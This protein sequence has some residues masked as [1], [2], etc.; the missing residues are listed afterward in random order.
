V[1]IKDRANPESRLHPRGGGTLSCHP[2][3]SPGLRSSTPARGN[4]VALITDG[5][6]LFGLGSIGPEATLPAMEGKSGHSC[7]TFGGI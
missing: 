5:S 3:G 4:T 1:P 6:A 2:Q 7:K